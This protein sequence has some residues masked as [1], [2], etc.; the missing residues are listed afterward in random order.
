M[1]LIDLTIPLGIG[2]LKTPRRRYGFS[3][4]STQCCRAAFSCRYFTSLKEDFYGSL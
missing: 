1:K 3:Q 2:M 4:V